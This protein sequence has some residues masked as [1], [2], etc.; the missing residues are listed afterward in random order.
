[1]SERTP[2]V[3]V[4]SAPSGG[5]KSTVLGRVLRE[6]PV[7]RFSV[8]HT[9][10]P[11]RLEETD[12]VQYHFVTEAAFEKL[13]GEGGFLEWAEVYGHRYGTS[14]AE[15]VRAR[16]DQVDLILDLDIQGAAQVRAALPDSVSVFILPPSYSDLEKRIRGRAQDDQATIERR[17][18]AAP[19]EIRAWSAYDYVLVND[20]LDA[21]VEDLKSV[22]RAARRRRS[23]MEDA[24]REILTSFES[25]QG[26]VKA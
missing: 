14:R 26:E 15:L 16:S 4:V 10:R 22:I 6:L 3:I 25:R 12:G 11:R 23:R 19:E 17:L 1:L 24:A 5:G 18:Q 13:R 8:S 7:L 21:C 9:T 2:S 20:H